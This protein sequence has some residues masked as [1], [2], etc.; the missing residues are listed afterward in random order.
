MYFIWRKSMKASLTHLFAGQ[1]V[2]GRMSRHGVLWFALALSTDT[3][4][5]VIAA[6]QLAVVPVAGE[7]VALA[8]LAVDHLLGVLALHAL[9]LAADT[10]SAVVAKLVVGGRVVGSASCG[11][12]G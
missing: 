9:A 5:V 8:E 7:V 2:A 10:V 1:A 6:A 12:S 4:P 3:G 11:T